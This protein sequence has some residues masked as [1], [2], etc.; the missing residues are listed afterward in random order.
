LKLNRHSGR[1]VL[2]LA[3]VVAIV[4]LAGRANAL[5]YHVIYD[6][7]QVCP[8]GWDPIAV[9]AAA[10]NG[11]LYGVTEGGGACNG[12]TIYKLT[13]PRTRGGAW[14]QAVLYEYTTNTEFPVSLVIG[15]DGALYGTGE[16]P[17]T[18]G[19]IF[20][21]TP[22]PQGKGTWKYDVLYTL[23]GSSDGSAPQG[24]LVFDANGN[25]YGATELGGGP[26]G[27][28][29]FEL[30]RPT[31]K[32]GKWRFGVLYTFTGKPDGAQPFAGVVFDQTGSLYGTTWE[33]GTFGWGTVYC[34]SPPAKKGQG[35]TET[36]LYSFSQSN[37]GII[38]PEGPV[39]FDKSGNLYGT[40]PSGGDL[41]CSGGYGCGVVFELSPPEKKGGAWNYATLYA[42]QG[43]NDGIIPYGYM[44][45]DQAL[46]LY[47]VTELGGV[48]GGGTVYRMNPPKQN[49]GVWT[50]TVLHGFTGN[51]GDG[52]DPDKGLTWGKWHDL[53][54]VT[55]DGG[56]CF[57]CGI[58]YEVGP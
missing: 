35:W 8:G 23:N 25:I 14:T 3:K 18:S 30:K 57:H 42:F 52:A 55:Q 1:V 9:P 53:Y 28:T 12:S 24:N 4:L 6:F 31:K 22:P 20:R 34:L 36:L 39:V 27:G 41:N 15:E 49:G 17:N 45:F 43:G 40:T 48:G 50:E 46:N 26:N 47:G 51:N 58:A 54:G 2:T 38:S 19:F 7:G 33:G 13:A 5:P 56:L 29:V 37:D 32:G 11:D 44:V 10:K 21:L 16:G